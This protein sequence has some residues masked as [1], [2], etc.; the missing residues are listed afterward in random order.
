M[1]STSGRS[2]RRGFTLVEVFFILAVI[3]I[4]AVLLKPKLANA[5]KKSQNISCVSHLKQ[6]GL[7][8]LAWA[9]DNANKTPMAVSTAKGGT[10]E[11]TN[12]ADTFRHF[13]VMSNELSNPLILACPSDTRQP[14]ADFTQLKNQ[15]VSYFVG[16]DVAS[17]ENPQMILD[18]DRN[19]TGPTSPEKGILKLSPGQNAAWTSTMHVNKG[20]VGLADGSVQAVSNSQLTEALRNS[21]ATTN[22]WRI[23]LPE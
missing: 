11:F 4:L 21:G 20:N 14:A 8:C 1:N 18:G 10:M 15:N 7:S 6:C 2:F 17:D 19:I 13:Q 3:A 12:G 5:E 23:S 16:L 9:G 22:I